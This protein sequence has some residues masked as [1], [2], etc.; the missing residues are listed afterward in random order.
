MKKTTTA[1]QT[2]KTTA[3]KKTDAPA[4]VKCRVL[5]QFEMGKVIIAGNHPDPL[6]I[7]EDEAHKLEKNGFVRIVGV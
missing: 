4:K 5:K 2:A 1:G 7:I 3:K 6:M